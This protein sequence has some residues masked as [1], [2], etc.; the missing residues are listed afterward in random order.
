[1]HQTEVD[2]DAVAV[3]GLVERLIQA[4][5]IGDRAQNAH[6][7]GQRLDLIEHLDA[8]EQLRHGAERL[9]C[10]LAAERLE[11][12]TEC[13]KRLVFDQAADRLGRGRIRTQL[14]DE[15]LVDLRVAEL[16][17]EVVRAG[18]AQRR[19]GSG[20]DVLVSRKTVRADQL[21]ADLQELA[22]VAV[23]AGD[24]TEHLLAVIQ[25]DRQSGVI[26]TGRCDTR[27][28]GGVI[29]T[30]HADPAGLVDD[31]E[32]LILVELGVCLRKHIEI[33]YGRGDDL[34]VT[35][36]LKRLTHRVLGLPQCTAGGKQKVTGTFGGRNSKTVHCS[37][38]PLSLYH[39]EIIPYPAR[40]CQP[41]LLRNLRCAC[42]RTQKLP[43]KTAAG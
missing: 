32:H 27:D 5:Q 43:E 28:G 16:D 31:L 15:S 20:E 37:A 26:Q 36:L 39:D 23:V 21:R 33:L 34:A 12:V 13:G 30:R 4:A 9:C 18:P 2:H 19:E 11:R 22:L 42:G 3:A 35:A 40:G 38:A 8:A 1:V 17:A 25:A 24:R 10:R 29:R 41:F 6:V 7:A 14:L